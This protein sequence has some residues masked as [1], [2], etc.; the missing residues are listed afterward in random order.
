MTLADRYIRLAATIEKTF[1]QE[2]IKFGIMGGLAQII[3]GDKDRRLGHLECITV[4]ADARRDKIVATVTK[5]PGMTL[6]WCD[7]NRRAWFQYKVEHLPGVLTLRVF[8]GQ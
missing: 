6:R 2:A 8:P 7:L 4:A 3:L 1:D 5:I